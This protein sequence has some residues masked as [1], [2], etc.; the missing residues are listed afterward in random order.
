MAEWTVLK[1]TNESD[2]VALTE[3]RAK[4]SW[5][6][7]GKQKSADDAELYF[8]NQRADASWPIAQNQYIEIW[9]HAAG[10]DWDTGAREYYGWV[11]TIKP[12]SLRSE[13][14]RASVVGPRAR[15]NQIMCQ[16]YGWYKYDWNQ[17]ANEDV[18]FQDVEPIGANFAYN[19]ERS[20]GS[21]LS[22]V[23]SVATGIYTATLNP[24]HSVD[25]DQGAG[26]VDSL[27]VAAVDFAS[28]NSITE[29][30]GQIQISGTSLNQIT[31]MLVEYT[32]PYGWYVRLSDK[33][34]IVIDLS[35]PPDATTKTID[36]G[37]VGEHESDAGNGV[38]LDLT[39]N[40]KDCRTHIVLEGDDSIHEIRPNGLPDGPA[41]AVGDATMESYWVAAGEWENKRYR[42]SK[43]EN[44][45]W[46]ISW[47]WLTSGYS[48]GEKTGPRLYSDDGGGL[49]PVGGSMIIYTISRGMVQLASANSDTM[50]IWTWCREPFKVEQ[51][52]GGA[53]DD[54]GFEA[55]HVIYNELLTSEKTVYQDSEGAQ[56]PA[57]NV[58][59]NAALMQTIANYLADKM[60]D[61]RVSGNI[62]VDE[63]DATVYSVGR[64]VEFS[65]V[66]AQ[67]I[68]LGLNIIG[69]TVDVA[70]KTSTLLVANDI[71]AIPGAEDLRRMFYYA[72]K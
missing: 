1:G 12:G 34:V 4:F 66:G 20:F 13:G 71:W 44:R 57:A 23:W 30:A 59:H 16:M 48:G 7:A 72:K 61:E 64:A 38:D 41:G 47:H 3:V 49:S 52:G 42:S 32:G 65:G 70:L 10:A 15:L 17:D 69:Y 29:N 9:S 6:L 39:F 18:G 36:F 14:L 43:P 55:D 28:M 8:P 24:L 60:G 25:G 22:E 68:G 63:V 31:A 5:G 46:A 54:Y 11:Q 33:T 51:T 27:V 19:E 56:Y 40:I 45:R 62:A 53:Y 2:L 58:P 37:A 35:A 67:Y 26:Y 50:Y 21:I